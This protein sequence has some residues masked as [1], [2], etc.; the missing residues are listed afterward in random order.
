M[1]A[2]LLLR[3]WQKIVVNWCW[4][5]LKTIWLRICLWTDT[6]QVLWLGV[7]SHRFMIVVFFWMLSFPACTT[8]ISTI[9][10]LIFENENCWISNKKTFSFIYIFSRMRWEWSRLKP[11]C[12]IYFYKFKA[13]LFVSDLKALKTTISI[14]SSLDKYTI[15]IRFDKYPIFLIMHCSSKNCMM[16]EQKSHF[17]TQVVLF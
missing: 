16:N 14:D 9:K 12:F 5:L 10:I 17:Y 6:N 11:F 13:M 8:E 7:S 2:H 1:A 4:L 3:W 15:G